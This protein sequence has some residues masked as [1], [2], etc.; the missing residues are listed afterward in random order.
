M[1]ETSI[2]NSCILAAS[3]AGAK[4]FRNNTGAVKTPDGRLLRF[5]L[6]PGSSDIIGWM[7]VKITPDMVGQTVAVF[8]A[9]EVKTGRGVVSDA[10]KRFIRAVR[11]DGG[12]GGVARSA[13]DAVGIVREKNFA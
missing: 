3:K 6:C 8:C 5:G 4:A 2:M 10:P 13:D 12:L 11:D 9:I 1:N 7:P